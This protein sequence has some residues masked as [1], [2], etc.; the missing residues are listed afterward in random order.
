TGT[1]TEGAP[2]LTNIEVFGQYD[3]DELLRLAASLDMVSPHVLATPIIKAAN[4][5]G[6]ELVFPEDVHEQLGSGIQGRVA[7]RLVSLGKSDWVLKGQA[8]PVQVRR[9]R[10]RSLLEGSSSVFIA[11]DGVPAGAII[12][13]DPVRHDAPLTI[14]AL[15]RV[16]F[17]KIVILTGDH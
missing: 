13:E 15:R 11:L 14:R 3:P 17:K 9:L 8:P 6:L 1:V 5:R 16:G 2:A 12:L 4:D 7:G 10:R